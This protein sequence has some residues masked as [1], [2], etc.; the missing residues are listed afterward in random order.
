[1]K[2]APRAIV[3]EQPRRQ[4]LERDVAIELLVVRA[5]DDA[6]AAGANFLQD[7]EVRQRLLDQG[8]GTI[9]AT[10]YPTKQP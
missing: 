10:H 4:H 6:H 3:G 2:A 5:V 9:T 7:A 8:H 1:M